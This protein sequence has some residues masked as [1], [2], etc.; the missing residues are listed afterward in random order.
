MKKLGLIAT[1]VAAIAFAACN[2]ASNTNEDAYSSDTIDTTLDDQ[3]IGEQLDEG[4]DTLEEVGQRAKKDIDATTAEAE[5]E[6]KTTGENIKSD[7]KAAKDDVG[8]AASAAG[9]D[10]KDAANKV[11]D[12]TKEGFKDAKEGVKDA[13]KKKDKE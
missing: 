1:F 12:K 8:D 5:V 9:K 4:I 3:T 11:A 13:T 10:I 2:N 7:L 6:A